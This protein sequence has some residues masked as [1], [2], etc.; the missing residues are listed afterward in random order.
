VHDVDDDIVSF[1]EGQKIADSW[2]NA[3][4]IQTKGLGHSLHSDKVYLKMVQFLTSPN[5]PL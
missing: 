4:F 1:S 3:D 2:K 5:N